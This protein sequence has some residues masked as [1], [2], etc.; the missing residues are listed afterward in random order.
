MPAYNFQARFAAS[1]SDGT[2][3]HTIRE[4]AA[5][6]GS[7]AYLFTGMRTK[8][9]KR[10]GQGTIT[11]CTPIEVGNHNGSPKCKLKGRFITSKAFETLAL[12]DGFA[13]TREMLNWFTSTYGHPSNQN[14]EWQPY[15]TGHL[16]E[17]RLEKRDA[18]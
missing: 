2:K 5:K 14:V 11:A 1:V 4:R 6:V 15:F 18:S 3:P 9:C 13:S 16:I 12:A 10:L 8:A 17:W 7:T